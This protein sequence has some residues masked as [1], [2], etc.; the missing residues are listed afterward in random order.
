MK[1]FLA[2]IFSALLVL[3][4]AA[5]AF[6]IHAEIPA[7]TQAVVAKGATQLTIGGDIRTRG[8]WIRNRVSGFPFDSKD[9]AYYDQRVRLYFDAAVTKDVQGYVMLETGTGND[10]KYFW[11]ENTFN[12]KG[13]TPMGLIQA[14]IQY[15]N[16]TL[17]GFPFGIKVGHMPLK[18][19]HSLFF[20]H[21]LGGDDAIVFFMDPTKDIHVGLLTVKLSDG[22]PPAGKFDNTDD[23]DAYVALMTYKMA[24]HTFGGNY[25]YIMNSDSRMK[26]SNLGLH[27]DGKVA[28]FGYKGE[29]DLQF[30]STEPTH[31]TPGSKKSKYKGYGVML[32]GSYAV[33]PV[34]IRAGL[35]YGSG[36]NKADTS[37]K[38]FQH[39][40]ANSGNTTFQKYTLIYE[41]LVKTAA[42]AT[43]TGIANTTYYNLGVD[44]KA[45]PELS[46]SVDAYLLRA[47]KT[48][49][50]ISKKVGWEIDAKVRYMLAKNLSYQVDLG[51][52]KAG[53]FYDDTNPTADVKST[54]VVR[55]MLTLS[56]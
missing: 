18:L 44:F 43:G 11:G 7:E 48:A 15:K 6:A 5:S 16:S 4:F 41:Y 25:T 17:F 56:F 21:T 22:T 45:T 42:G 47:S 14:W 29:A 53:D 32:E 8:W 9:G 39:F 10:D 3:S 28:G 12:A 13:G 24:G 23:L 49:S 20:D 50:G 51:Y 36:D 38:T 26:F 2:I 54:A 1:K 19:S 55:N 34:T 35:A 37:I 30:G 27:A 33:N 46:G 40:S 31:K 52:L